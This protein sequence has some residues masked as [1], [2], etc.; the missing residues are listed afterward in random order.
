MSI[1]VSFLQELSELDKLHISNLKQELKEAIAQRDAAQNEAAQ[2][3]AQLRQLQSEILIG[4]AP[5]AEG[6][7]PSADSTRNFIEQPVSE[8]DTEFEAGVSASAQL[9]AEIE[10][11]ADLTAKILALEQEVADLRKI[12]QI[13]EADVVSSTQSSPIKQ[14]LTVPTRDVTNS[15]L[16]E[17]EQRER[18]LL[19]QQEFLR[20]QREDEL[21]VL[22]V[23]LKSNAGFADGRPV[24]AAMV[25]KCCVQ[26]KAFQLEKTNIFER[27]IKTISD[28]IENN[29]GNIGVLAYWLSNTVA[30]INLM[31]THVK[32]ARRR[33]SGGFTPKPATAGSNGLISGASG[34]S[35]SQAPSRTSSG[36]MDSGAKIESKYY[37][38]LFQKQLGTLLPRIFPMLR[39]NVKKQIS[40][41]L[42]ACAYVYKQAQE[43][44]ASD[45][46]DSNDA[47][48]TTTTGASSAERYSMLPWEQVISILDNLLST[49]QENYVPKFLVQKLFEQLFSFLNAQLFNQLLLRRECCAVK[50]GEYIN[51]GLAE[52]DVWVSKAGKEWVGDS[53]SQ[54]SHLRQG[55]AFLV[56]PRKGKRSL[57]ELMREICPV[58]S[59]QQLYRFT[60]MFWDYK[61]GAEPLAQDVLQ[62]LK[63]LIVEAASSPEANS[64]LLLDDST[65]PFTE[66]DIAKLAIPQEIKDTSRFA[67]LKKTF[68]WWT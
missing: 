53:F 41:H 43:G 22:L 66:E 19:A 37:G 67:F 61:D 14:P 25:F 2:V 20:K 44:P 52:I 42:G 12:P 5:R 6:L 11:N 17:W 62:E 58:L 46:G 30:L 28:Q 68:D 31:Q 49:V 65:I 33:S 23:A 60:T 47:A 1:R 56:L 18:E 35:F 21:E 38:L 3:T 16:I 54:L 63:K 50:N 29:Q 26:W 51:A 9:A 10:K 45:T 34:G 48:A 64:F 7:V 8:K 13:N 24:G 39:D 15:S 36:T 55:A 4:G 59:V 27:I 32:P 57:Q 40:P